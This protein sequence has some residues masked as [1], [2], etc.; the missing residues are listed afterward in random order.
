MALFQA[1]RAAFCDEKIVKKRGWNSRI[2]LNIS[3]TNKGK[4]GIWHDIQDVDMKGR[5]YLY[6]DGESFLSWLHILM[7]G[8]VVYIIHFI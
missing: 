6:D 7:L 2:R 1:W 3:L 4:D 5:E 8:V